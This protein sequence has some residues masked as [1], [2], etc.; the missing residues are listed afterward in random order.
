MG[1]RTVRRAGG[2]SRRE[3][4]R[5]GGAGL[6]GAAMLGGAGCGG[7]GSEA[8]TI[9]FTFGPD[10]SGGLQTLIDRFNEQNEGALQVE[11]RETPAASDEYF[12]Q[13]LSE[14]QSGKS[15]VD[16]IGGDV[17]WPAQFAANGFLVDLS[18]RFTDQMKADHLDGPLQPITYEGK[19]YGVPWFTDAGMFYYRKDLLEESGFSQPPKT[20]D[21]M[22]EMVAKIRADSGEEYDGYVFQGAQ[23]EGGV[24]NGLEHIWNAGGE[25]LEGDRV[26]VN[27]AEAVE[28][29]KLRRSMIEDGIAPVATGDYSTQESQAAFTNGDVI[30]MRNWPFVYGLL[31]NPDQSQVTPEQVGIAPIPVSGSGAQSF[32]GLGGWNFLINAASE[33][34]IEEIW[35][36]VEFM[37]APEQQKTLVLESTRLPTLKSL[38]E[39]EELLQKVPVASL[40]R[41]SLENSRP[42]PVSPYYSDMSLEMA[43]QFNAALKG[44]EPVEQA[45]ETLQ[46][47]LQAIVDQGRE[48]RA[49]RRC[50]RHSATHPTRI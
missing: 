18:D 2:I 36:F 39:D 14:L 10:N 44:E 8:D 47:E 22:K 3:F 25:V 16:V 35:A 28:G 41:E 43:G 17:V 48:G 40:G 4:L 31:S 30:F 26:V 33:D 15:T 11:W 20:W 45:L 27:S 46:R 49:A 42:R 9:T 34:R 24:V 23:D 29:L 32:S 50:P 1:R 38:Y 12:E 19:T 7:G 37:I 5:L 21:E 6:A 13:M